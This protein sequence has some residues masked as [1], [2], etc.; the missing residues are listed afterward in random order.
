MYGTCLTSSFHLYSID[1]ARAITMC[2]RRTLRDWLSKSINEFYPTIGYV[3][4]IEKEFST[5]TIMANDT[6]YKFGYNEEITV[7]R[8]GEEL[9]ILANKFNKDTDLLGIE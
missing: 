5:V 3:N 7:Q 6:E 1:C 8:N 2:A 4:E 9:K